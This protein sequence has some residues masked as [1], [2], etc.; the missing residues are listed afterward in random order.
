[1]ATQFPGRLKS[2]SVADHIGA[3]PL[4][5]LNRVPSALGIKAQVYAKLEYF[6]AGGQ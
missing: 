3:T 2:G 6:N 5:R 1:M 4:V